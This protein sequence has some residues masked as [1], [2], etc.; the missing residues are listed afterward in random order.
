MSVESIHRDIRVGVKRINE[1]VPASR[2]PFQNPNVCPNTLSSVLYFPS[3]TQDKM[4]NRVETF[5]SDTHKLLA[6]ELK[7]EIGEGWG[8]KIQGNGN[9][10][11]TKK[12]TKSK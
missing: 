1:V 7:E 12:E 3:Y 10:D 2:I 8:S 5:N 4:A 9:V 11:Q 6:M